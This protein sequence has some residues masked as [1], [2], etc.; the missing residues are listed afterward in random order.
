MTTT[1]IVPGIGSSE[2]A[3]WQTW[4]ANNIPGSVRVAQ[5]DWN[6]ANLADWSS[7]IRREISRSSGRVLIAA[8]SFGVLAAVQAAGDHAHR[9]AGVL[10]VAP[11]DPEK[12]GVADY[13]PHEALAFPAIVVA[14]ANDP[15]M[16]ADRAAHWAGVWGAEL[17][18]LGAAG[19][20]NTEAGFGPWPEGLRLIERL[21][22]AAEWKE[23]GERL[24]RL[25]RRPRRASAGISRPIVRNRFA[26]DKSALKQAAELLEQAGWHVAPPS[27]G[28]RVTSV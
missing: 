16:T 5:R 13:L 6:D 11:A 8:H 9:I 1:L 7:R 14:S 18:N 4:L 22:S 24:A 23:S 27:R 15:W 10:L 26:D 19:H 20:I 28:L 3:H 12:F 2:P 17:I 21:R 25:A